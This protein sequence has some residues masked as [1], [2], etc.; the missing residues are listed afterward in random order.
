M[1]AHRG[2]P[3]D[4]DANGTLRV[5]LARVAGYSPRDAIWMHPRTTLRGAIAKH[6]G[7]PPFDLPA[8]VRAAADRAAAS[9]FADRALGDLPVDFLA[10][11]DTTGGN[12]GSPVLDGRGRLVGVN[13]DRVWE[14]VANDFAH[15]PA[16]CRSVAVDIRYVL[17]LL[18]HTEGASALLTELGASGDEALTR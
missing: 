8:A 16:V 11:A 17:W 13:F 12:S 10:D 7:E 6:T 3:L 15:D 9:R 4:P 18:D 2:G 5:S 14:N 1:A